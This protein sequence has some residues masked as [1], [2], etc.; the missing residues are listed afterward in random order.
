MLF[1]GTYSVVCT[2]PI[3][4]KSLKASPKSRWQNRY[5]SQTA[6]KRCLDWWQRIKDNKIGVNIS[7]RAL[8]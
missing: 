1:F 7:P 4:W 5:T 3:V 8:C 2:M 6:M